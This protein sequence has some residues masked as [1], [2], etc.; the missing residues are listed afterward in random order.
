MYPYICR[1][2]NEKGNIVP[3]AG[4]KPKSLAFQASVLPLHH[5]GFPEVTTIPT[6]TYLCGSL[7]QRS[8]QIHYEYNKIIYNSVADSFIMNIRNVQHLRQCNTIMPIDADI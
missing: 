1:G 6:P 4:I 7:P 3:R 8:V 5:I 2:C